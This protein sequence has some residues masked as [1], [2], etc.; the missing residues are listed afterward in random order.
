MKYNCTRCG[1]SNGP[2][3]Q[4]ICSWRCTYCGVTNKCECT[5]EKIE[6]DK[7]FDIEFVMDEDFYKQ[8]NLEGE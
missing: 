6:P 8:L 3:T 7:T 2:F 1:S 4:D 5:C